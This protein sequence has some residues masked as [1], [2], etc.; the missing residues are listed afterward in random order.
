MLVLSR[1]QGEA[2]MIGEVEITIV[3]VTGGAVRVGINA[4]KEVKIL[5]KE[6]IDGSSD[7]RTSKESVR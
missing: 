5:R 1:K 2:I 6:L 3:R 4:P 7:G